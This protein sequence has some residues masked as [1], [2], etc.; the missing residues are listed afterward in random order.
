MRLTVLQELIDIYNEIECC[1][2]YIDFEEIK[3]NIA[4]LRNEREIEFYISLIVG[5]IENLENEARNNDKRKRR[6]K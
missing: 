2:V 3:S 4:D 6:A 5:R 1:G